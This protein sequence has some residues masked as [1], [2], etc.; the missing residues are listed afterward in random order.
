MHRVTLLGGHN[1]QPTRIS[2]HSNMIF[3]IQKRMIRVIMNVDI[4]TS[5]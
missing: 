2:R 1:L 5:C 4:R 3:K